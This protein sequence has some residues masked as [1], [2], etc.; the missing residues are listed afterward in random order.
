MEITL[1]EIIEWANANDYTWV[2]EPQVSDGGMWI[3]SDG[4][5]VFEDELIEIIEK[6]RKETEDTY[7]FLN[8][9][10]R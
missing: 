6:D 10:A 2:D 9:W 7:K 1:D 5:Q 8:W 4:E 3:G